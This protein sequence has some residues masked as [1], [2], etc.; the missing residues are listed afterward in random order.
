MQQRARPA[1]RGRRPQGLKGRKLSVFVSAADAATLSSQ[2]KRTHRG[3]VS[4][5]IADLIAA[6]R[7]QQA[8]DGVLRELGG[9]RVTEEDVAAIRREVATAGRR[10]RRSAA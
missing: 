9:D 1:P 3:N 4:A 8:A 10:R 7:R 2:A 5:V 6:L